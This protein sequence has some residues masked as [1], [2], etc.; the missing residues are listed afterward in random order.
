[1][2]TQLAETYVRSQCIYT[3]FNALVCMCWYYYYIY[4]LAHYSL[5]F[6]KETVQI[7]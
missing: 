2:A 3:N 1:M 5:T 6:R 4:K 7:T